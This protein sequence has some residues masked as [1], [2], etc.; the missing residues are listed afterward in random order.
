MCKTGNHVITTAYPLKNETK[1]NKIIAQ[2]PIFGAENSFVKRELLNK[3]K[4]NMA[5]EF[6]YGEDGDFVRRLRNLGYDVL[7]FSEPQ[8]L[9]LKHQWVVLGQNQFWPGIVIPFSPNHRQP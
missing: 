9:Q 7:Y 3:V 5:L 8:I 2:W 4:F 1:T 6:G